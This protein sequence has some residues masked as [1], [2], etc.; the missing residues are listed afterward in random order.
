MAAKAL[1]VASTFLLGLGTAGFAADLP[2]E[3]VLPVPPV[4]VFSWT[5]PYVG[6]QGGFAW[7][8][9]EIHV[10]GDLRDEELSPDGFI[11]GGFL[12]Y[13]WQLASG[14]IIGAEA[15]FEWADLND[16]GSNAAGVDFSTDMNWDG[17]I[18]SRAGFAWDR[19]LLYIT[20]GFAFADLEGEI[21]PGPSASSV[22][23][24]WTAGAG[25]DYAFTDRVFG[26]VEYRFTDLS[27]FDNDD[28]AGEVQDFR[29]HAIRGGVG[30]KF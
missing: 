19:A 20:S 29:S 16:S 23:W 5:G 27:D 8:E 21:N 26:R 17:S 11:I 22:D 14:W 18:R 10:P 3:P 2:V 1:L 30:V 4:V 13:N 25:V 24:G 7:A 6:I 28:D 9:S 12:G 15:D